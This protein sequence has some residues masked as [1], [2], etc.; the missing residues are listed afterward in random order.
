[1]GPNRGRVTTVLGA[2]SL[3]FPDTF[4]EFSS[5]RCLPARLQQPGL[6]I[7]SSVVVMKEMS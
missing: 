7:G 5:T 4:F 1:M 2:F 6:F 3:I